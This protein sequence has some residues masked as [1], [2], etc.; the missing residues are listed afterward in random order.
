MYIYLAFIGIVW[1]DGSTTADYVYIGGR[2]PSTNVYKWLDNTPF[3]S[4][5]NNWN[6][7]S[8]ISGWVFINA[9]DGLWGDYY[10]GVGGWLCESGLVPETIT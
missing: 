2:S 3:T 10:A 1:G 8:R 6:G 7:Y 5:Y 4:T 9:V